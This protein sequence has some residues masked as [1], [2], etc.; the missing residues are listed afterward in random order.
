M[1]I[2]K[3]L[4]K[5]K[6]FL[7]RLTKIIFTAIICTLLYAHFIEPNWID[8]NYVQLELPNLVSEFKGYRIV[9]IS[10]IHVDKQSKKRCLNHIF[11]LVNQ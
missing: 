6:F 3:L 7:S 10:D 9:Q 2:H 1:K 11:Q 5:A 8:L 4:F